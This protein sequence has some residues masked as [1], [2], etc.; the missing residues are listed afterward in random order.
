MP[1][2]AAIIEARMTSSRL[3]GKVLK[4]ILGKSTLELMIERLRKIQGLGDIII[5]STSNVTDDPIAELG[6]KLGVNVWRGSEND[7][8]GRVVDAALAFDVDVIVETTGDCP[9]IDPQIVDQGITAFQKG[10]VDCVSNAF[11][12][13]YPLGMDYYIVPTPLLAASAEIAKDQVERENVIRY[14]KWHPEKYRHLNLPA[15]PEH[16]YPNLMLTLDYQEDFDLI[17]A[18]FERLYPTKPTFDLNDIIALIKQKP[19]LAKINDHLRKV[20]A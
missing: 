5:A 17:K 12:P 19:E 7:V 8:L 1:H 2:F 11:T 14:I 10:A 6:K 13:T 15:A 4:E 20:R 18:V 9:L 3:P 16:T